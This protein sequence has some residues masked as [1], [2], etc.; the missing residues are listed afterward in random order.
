MPEPDDRPD[1]AL[2]RLG[3]ELKAFEAA[4]GRS[5]SSE[6]NQSM[7]E[8]YRLFAGLIGGVLGGVGLGWLVDRVV[9]TTPW[10]ILIG[11]V[12]GAGVS[13]FAAVRAAS[14]ISRKALEKAG[15]LPSVPDDDDDE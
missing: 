11:A 5:A 3:E 7:A 14:R 15:P 4:R 8:G 1:E 10:G 2:G 13:V 9:H 12:V 6:A